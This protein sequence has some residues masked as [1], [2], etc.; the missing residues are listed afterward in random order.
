ME[1]KDEP[2]DDN[3]KN[4][5]TKEDFYKSLKDKPALF[6]TST[7]FTTNLPSTN[8]VPAMMAKPRPTLA[9]WSSLDNL[10]AH[11]EARQSWR[12][13]TAALSLNG[14][15]YDSQTP[16]TR[17]T[18]PVN[19]EMQEL[20]KVNQ[21]HT[22]SSSPSAETGPNEHESSSAVKVAFRYP[23]SEPGF[24]FTIAMTQFIAE[25]LISG[26]A[27][28]LPELGDRDEGGLGLFWPAS[29]LTLILSATLLIFA[30]LSDMFGG[31]Y[32]LQFGTIWLF[33][34][35]LI[36]GFYPQSVLLDVSR[37]MQGLAL[38]AFVP[39]AIAMMGATYREGRRKNL[40][41]S[42]YS[43]CAPLGFFAGFLAGG[44]LPRDQTGWYFWTASILSA[45]TAVTAYLCVPRHKHTPD[46][47]AMKM[48]YIGAC[49]ITGGLILLSY[50]L[51]VVT[52]VNE[53]DP[54]RTGWSYPEVYIPLAIGLS[55]LAIAFWYEGW[56]ATC[57][58]IP[59][60]FFKPRSVKGFCLACLFF[61]AAF[62]VWLY[63]SADFF[64][65]PTATGHLNGIQ[66]ITLAVWYTP[67]AIGGVL[68]CLIGGI[69]MDRVPANH[70][71][72]VSALAWIGAPLILALAPLPLN[73]WTSVLTS[74]LCATIG[75]DL[76][77]T[78]SLI[79]LTDVQPQK[80]Q[81][82]AG[83]VCSILINLAM[84]FSLSVGE[85]L[86]KSAQDGLEIDGPAERD[87]GA[88][89][90]AAVGNELAT[91][92]NW[93][94]RVTFMYAAASAFVGLV[95]VVVNVRIPRQTGKARVEEE[96]VGR[97]EEGMEEEGAGVDAGSC[98]STLVG[99]RDRAVV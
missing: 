69:I 80:Y 20:N 25:Y 82:F 4:W 43:S 46:N 39:S 42:I 17:P 30:R 63:N 71:L 48:D 21:H 9:T 88:P 36:P 45:I 77:F 70:T 35:T 66:G 26:F 38:A 87:L 24:C 57:P 27:V 12:R 99:Q 29:L 89:Q 28:I 55:S 76:T 7:P 93:G 94:F 53:D 62:G 64:A 95:V 40:V 18:S 97:E 65:S 13:S 34:W 44:A 31:Y 33:I 54:S 79:F 16:R 98:A 74:T 37:A 58:L 75:L 3:A 15:G 83:A 11:R 41:M 84:S 47:A 23:F 51:S 2:E 91:R 22:N 73:Y 96:E 50:G 14:G 72:T 19:E 32:S 67:T 68:F 86:F 90:L 78:I 1:G 60:D 6:S 56:V 49:L 59:F 81:G 61:Y 10:M 52:Y 5:H 92:Y 8:S 85:I